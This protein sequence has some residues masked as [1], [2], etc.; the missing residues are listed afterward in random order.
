MKA[1]LS[2]TYRYNETIGSLFIL[3]GEELLYKCKA[4]E[5]PW[6]GNQRN[7][8]CI[9]EGTYDC[10]KIISPTKGEVIHVL[11]VYGRDSILIHKGNYVPKDTKG[12][13]LP[14]NYFIDLDGDGTPDIAESTKAMTKLLKVLPEKF[15]LYII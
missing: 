6:N 1:V 12:C 2:R 11:V 9:P 14:G 15:K 8:S 13:I 4:L 10:E 7:V 3:E 5:L